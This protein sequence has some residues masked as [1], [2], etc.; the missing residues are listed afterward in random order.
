MK[1]LFLIILFVST[2]FADVNESVSKKE[3]QV[4]EEIEYSLEFN[5]KELSELVLPKEGFGPENSDLPE[6]YIEVI[7][8]EPNKLKVNMKFLSSGE[9]NLPIAWK[10]EKGELKTSNIKVKVL[11][12]ITES[13]KEIL[14]IQ[15]PLEFSGN[16]ILR[17]I[18]IILG[19]FLI[20][21]ILSYFLFKRKTKVPKI[22]DA[23]FETIGERVEGAFELLLNELLKSKESIPHKEFVYTLSG[24]VK[25]RLEKI[26]DSSIQYMTNQELKEVWKTKLRMDEFNAARFENYFSN[27]KYMPND[28]EI[29]IEKAKN[30]VSEWRQYLRI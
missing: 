14:D 24:F 10:D 13:D 22:K 21:G 16:F 25:E 19:I 1:Y 4:G 20:I 11:S 17:I 27:I 26:T 8:N 12:S 29:S 18:L 2:L 15:E 7:E 23:S 28:E 3:V 5:N 30:L 9:K 6:Y